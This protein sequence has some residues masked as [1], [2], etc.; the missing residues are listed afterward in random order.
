MVSLPTP[1]YPPRSRRLGEEG[2]VLLEVEVLPDGRAGKVRVLQ[3]PPYER[4][5]EAAIE[6]VRRAKF[7]PATVDGTAVRATVE[8]PIR[9]KLHAP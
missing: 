8:V 1:E 3:A 7:K 9:F 6:V 4:L 2:L 5:V